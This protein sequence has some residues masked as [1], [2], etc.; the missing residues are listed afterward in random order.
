VS[1]QLLCESV[2]EKRAKEIIELNNRIARLEGKV[3]V[4]T[5]R[6]EF[7]ARD[8]VTKDDLD[9]LWKRVTKYVTSAIREFSSTL[10]TLL[11]AHGADIK[12]ADRKYTRIAMKRQAEEQAKTR[13]RILYYGLVTLSVVMMMTGKDGAA[14]VLRWASSLFGI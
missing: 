4:L 10:T 14:S 9:K 6:L 1:E 5:T 7:L 13:R 3:D 2:A 12:R 8:S 11:Q